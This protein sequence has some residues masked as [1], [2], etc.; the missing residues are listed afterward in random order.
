MVKSALRNFSFFLLFGS[1]KSD[2]WTTLHGQ[3]DQ[4]FGCLVFFT[5]RVQEKRHVDRQLYMVKSALRVFSFFYWSGP[6]KVTCGQ[7]GIVL[8]REKCCRPIYSV[9][10]HDLLG[11]VSWLSL[12]FSLRS[13]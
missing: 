6:S 10:A 11:P 12:G 2:M 8:H 9:S 13:R 1:K 4:L 7:L 5:G 3:V